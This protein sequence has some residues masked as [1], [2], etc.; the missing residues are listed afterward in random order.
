VGEEDQHRI[1]L[2]AHHEAGHA[3][4]ASALGFRLRGVRIDPATY[5]GSTQLAE[6]ERPTRLQ[7]VLILLAGG[8]AELMLD[9][10]SLA[11]SYSTLQDEV[12]LDEII[13]AKPASRLL[14][15]PVSYV[16]GIC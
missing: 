8:R 7:H 3:A 6:G 12:I 5:N 15:R 2:L 10:W 13:K 16:D 1:V 14:N 11:D 9:P 4:I